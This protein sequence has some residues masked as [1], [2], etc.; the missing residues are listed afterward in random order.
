MLL[1]R[2]RGKNYAGHMQKILDPRQRASVSHDPEWSAFPFRWH[3]F[4]PIEID[5]MRRVAAQPAISSAGVHNRFLCVIRPELR[6]ARQ[7]AAF[8]IAR[9][10]SPNQGLDAG[11]AARGNAGWSSPV[12]RQAHN[13]K[14]VGSNPAPATK[15]SNKIR[16]LK[17]RCGGAFCVLGFSEYMAST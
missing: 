14:V 15:F 9:A 6:A 17:L 8:L 12:A 11:D 16:Y 1:T 7:R 10:Q 4:A 3:V 5:V 13:L 2:L